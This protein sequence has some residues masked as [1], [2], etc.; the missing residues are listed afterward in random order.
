MTIWES[1]PRQVRFSGKADAQQ[2]KEVERRT[3]EDPAP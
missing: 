3:E 2:I 1:A